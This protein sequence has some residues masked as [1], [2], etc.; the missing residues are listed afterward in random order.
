MTKYDT[1]NEKGSSTF[2]LLP[3]FS[4]FKEQNSLRYQYAA[5]FCDT[6]QHVEPELPELITPVIPEFCSG[7]MRCKFKIRF[8]YRPPLS[9][10]LGD[11][12]LTPNRD[13]SNISVP[14]ICLA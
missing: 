11:N 8:M 2:A 4:D 5:G 9:F 14:I 6:L 7:A 12:F 1:G 13:V 10:V 3:F